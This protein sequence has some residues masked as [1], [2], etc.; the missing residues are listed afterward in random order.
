MRPIWWSWIAPKA[1]DR[2]GRRPTWPY[3]NEVSRTPHRVSHRMQMTPA[4]RSYPVS[5]LESERFPCHIVCLV[6]KIGVLLFVP[7]G[8]QCGRRHF[9]PPLSVSLTSFGFAFLLSSSFP[10]V[11]VF[12]CYRLQF[13]NID[14]MESTTC[15]FHS[16]PEFTITATFNKANKR[17][18]GGPTHTNRMQIGRPG[19]QMKGPLARQKDRAACSVGKECKSGRT[20]PSRSENDAICKLGG[21]Y[22]NRRSPSSCTNIDGSGRFRTRD[23][24]PFVFDSDVSSG[25]L[26]FFFLLVLLLGFAGWFCTCGPQ[27]QTKAGDPSGESGGLFNDVIRW[28]FLTLIPF[29]L[30]NQS[31]KTL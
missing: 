17:P 23:W 4:P 8:P 24:R 20:R 7:F 16:L 29:H 3:A 13:C 30:P 1:M 11:S 18:L 14:L 19:M 10:L 26:Y 27:R 21:R 9:T 12:F 15:R 2:H 28:R 25:F 6:C 31:S 22:A 5:H